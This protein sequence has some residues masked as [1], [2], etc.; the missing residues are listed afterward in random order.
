MAIE[1]VHLAADTIVVICALD[2]E[3]GVLDLCVKD[4]ICVWAGDR[5]HVGGINQIYY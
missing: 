1:N 2:R 3:A 4:Q 5:N